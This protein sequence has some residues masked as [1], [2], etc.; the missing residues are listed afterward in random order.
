M[1]YLDIL[2]FAAIA[3]FLA[4]RL[5]DVLGERRD[6]EPAT[7][8]LT[9]KLPEV[10]IIDEV[11]MKNIGPDF[12]GKSEILAKYPQFDIKEFMTGAGAALVM[13]V[14]AFEKGQLQSIKPYCSKDVIDDFTSALEARKAAGEVHIFDSM[15]LMD[16][17]LVQGKV[18]GQKIYIQVRFVSQQTKTI[19]DDKGE[20]LEQQNDEDYVDVWTFAR[21][22]RSQ[23]PNWMLVEADTEENTEVGVFDVD[24]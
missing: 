15:H 3:A 1:A 19:Q 2:F 13:I 8:G 17:T 4:M 7:Q 16:M 14:E 23:D 10:K 5:R 24:A 20:V 9:E 18:E 22:I 11:A 12:I 6:D 21:S